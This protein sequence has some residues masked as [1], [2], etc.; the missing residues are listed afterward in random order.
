[1]RLAGI[2]A[3]ARTLRNGHQVVA[4]ARRLGVPLRHARAVGKT[5]QLARSPREYRRRRQLARALL[6]EVPPPFT[7]HDGYAEFV[8]DALPH[9]PQA[10]E[11]CRSVAD[12]ERAAYVSKPGEK[13][14]LR[15]LLSPD[16]LRQQPAILDFATSPEITAIVTE[17]LGTVPTLSDA[18]LWWSVPTTSGGPPSSSQKFHRDHEDY[19]QVKVLVNVDEVTPDGGP[20]TFLPAARSEQ[21]VRAMGARH[22]RLEDEDVLGRASADELVTLT[23]PSGHAAMVDTCRCLHYGSRND[24]RERLVL[25]LHYVGYHSIVE[26]DVKVVTTD[27]RSE[28]SSPH[29]AVDALLRTRPRGM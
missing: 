9:G 12:A 24:A 3:H 17:Y 10:L 19:R 25:M 27:V 7:L 14:F 22:G 26:P 8:V 6:T 20:F 15:S 28:R 21:V 11:A 4:T 5:V 29:P 23:G 16:T 1:M 13:G 2:P 18:R